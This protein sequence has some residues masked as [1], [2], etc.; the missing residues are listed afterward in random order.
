MKRLSSP[1]TQ[2]NNHYDAIVIGSGYG[3]AI[4]AS[5][6]GRM[7]TTN[8][9]PLQVCLLERGREIQ[10]GEYPD[11]LWEAGKEF[12]IDLP[13]K[14]VGDPTGLF[15]M[16]VGSDMNVMV[17]CGLGGT[18]LINANVSIK[19]DARVYEDSRWPKPVRE[20]KARLDTCY[21]RALQMLGANPFPDGE[22]GIP[23][24]P[25]LE[26]Q[27]K[28]AAALGKPITCPPINVTFK[29][30]LSA[31]GVAQAACTHCGD[32]VSGCN[33]GAK[34]TTLMNY[35]PD[36]WNNGVEI[37]TEVSVRWLERDG[38]EW[39]V[40]C[41]LVDVGREVFGGADLVLRTQRVFVGAGTLGSTEIMLR[42]K[43]KGLSLSDQ[44]GHQFTSNGD[45]LGF[46]YNND[47]KINSIGFGNRPVGDVDPVGPCITSMIDDRN[48]D[49]LEQGLIMEE[50]S[51]P[52][53]LSSALPLALATAS[54]VLGEDT[55]AGFV[56]SLQESG[57]VV[58][59][60]VRGAYHG[61]MQNTQVYLIMSHDDSDGRMVLKDDRVRIDWP[62]VGDKP[63]FQR[64]S[65]FLE[66]A[67]A[68][69][70]GTYIPNP[71]WTKALGNPLVTVHPLGGCCMAEQAASGVVDHR[72]RVFASN[73]GDQVHA[74]LYVVDG[75]IIPRSLGVNPLL[76]ISAMAE[77]SMALMAEA[78]GFEYDFDTPSVPRDAE[79]TTVGVR[80]T[81]TMRGWWSP[82][83]DYQSA[84]EAGKETDNILDF[85]LTVRVDDVDALLKQGGAYTAGMVGTVNAPSLSSSALTVTEGLFNLFARDPD[86]VGMELMKYR[87]QMH[88]VE[89]QTWYFEGHKKIHNDAGID[90][91]A[92]T[93]ELY[94]TVYDGF[95]ATA[96]VTG[97][98]KLV[99]RPLD[100]ARQITTI[101]ATGTLDKMARLKAIS[102]FG[103]FFAGDLYHV[104]G[105]ILAPLKY[106][107]PDALPRKKR[108]L[109]VGAPTVH[110][111]M[112]EDGVPLRLT[113]YCGGNK[114]PLLLIH[115]AGVSSKIFS[116]DTIDT[117]LLEYLYLNGYD[118]WLL[119]MRISVDLPSSKQPWNLDDVAN[120]DLPAA[121]TTILDVTGGP[122]VQV[123]AHCA[124]S[125]VFFMSMMAGLEHV[126]GAVVSQTGPDQIVA[127]IAQAKAGLHLPQMLS[128]I[129]VD[130]LTT[131]V[132]KES[133]WVDK[134][135]DKFLNLQPL[136]VE[137]RCNSPVC[138]RISFM[139]SLLYE[140]DQL[141]RA[142]HDNLHEMFGEC[143]MEIFEHLARNAREKH[144]VSANGE[145]IYMPHWDRL[146]LPI[147]FIHGA[148][149]VCY[150]PETTEKSFN[151]LVTK[152]G[153]DLYERHVIPHYGHI[154]CIFGK[155]AVVDVYPHIVNA[156]NKTNQGR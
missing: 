124:G 106:L 150:L 10:T 79:P 58:E 38:D 89:G 96:A 8:G 102:K 120:H 53:A 5:R 13:D 100:F 12:Q 18:S 71:L 31:S 146:K 117:N 41:R 46:A 129:G 105:G 27:K 137:E 42:S 101:D 144:L 36:A 119:D 125:T 73:E 92:D 121:I 72:S 57:R 24:L 127:P 74:G 76:T 45:V 148:E 84:M 139:Y 128:F 98:G 122:D 110:G 61:A 94:V 99:I 29:D 28:S 88:S 6:L 59:S 140:H 40:H 113:R 60:L 156:L 63:I 37:Y 21:D 91:W 19:A 141:N 86:R 65:D 50:G 25:K 114:G 11:T 138:H 133:G 69:N 107:D 104:Y 16:H 82:T 70:G 142:T 49:D 118:C 153:A 93:T 108:N 115:G 64:D 126:R 2:I 47:V 43:Q 56:D 149:N 26:A 134:L 97:K 77:R 147:T 116:T 23:I 22:E 20:D 33:V 15:D 135:S 3:G 78:E 39:R 17:G 4:A 143:S 54:G 109:R 80:F 112:T 145:D 55:D 111:F 30:G 132:D 68:A 67:T 62:G 87:F 7:K 35:L 131:D 155:N 152:N 154:D 75:S 90:I 34:N 123:F 85:T 95:D 48:T 1:R 83:G 103:L 81:E 14:H 51:L 130:S 32:C 66:H 52:G 9:E 136:G 44:L 151:T